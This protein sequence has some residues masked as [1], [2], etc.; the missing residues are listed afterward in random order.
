MLTD[1]TT[2]SGYWPFACLPQNT[3]PAAFQTKL[4]SL[5][6]DDANHQTLFFTKS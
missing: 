2:S 1:P 6:T 4:A 5:S 3:D